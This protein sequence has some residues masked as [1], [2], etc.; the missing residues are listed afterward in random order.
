MTDEQKQRDRFEERAFNQRF[1]M[2]I[3]KL[4]EGCMTL[5]AVECPTKA[6]FVKRRDDGSYEDP[7]LNA[8]WWAWLEAVAINGGPQK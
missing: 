5:Q 4:G 7:T 8:M 3:R 6:D 2:S 1:L